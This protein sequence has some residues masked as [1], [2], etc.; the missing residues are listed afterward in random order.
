MSVIRM[1]KI[2]TDGNIRQ[3]V[4]DIESLAAYG[5]IED[6]PRAEEEIIVNLFEKGGE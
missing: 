6:H 2:K 1:S 3:E 4:G 5:Y